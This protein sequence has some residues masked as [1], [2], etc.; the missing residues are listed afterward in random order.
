M[1]N[2]LSSKIVDGINSFKLFSSN[3]A[4]DGSEDEHIHCFK[5]D[6]SYST[7]ATLLKQATEALDEDQS[8]DNPFKMFEPDVIE[9][10]ESIHVIDK[11]SEGDGN[12]DIMCDDFYL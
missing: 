6:S 2:G 11:D 12:I 3:L 1:W 10:Y 8:S 7:G 9:R 4:A 5:K